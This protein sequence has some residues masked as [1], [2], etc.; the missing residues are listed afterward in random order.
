MRRFVISFA[1]VVL[2]TMG[3][4]HDFDA[5]RPEVERGT[6]GEEVFGIFCDRMSGQLLREDLSGA[7][8]HGVC[9][10]DGGAFADK[11]DESALPPIED[12]L[13][14]KDG[15]PVP[16]G[17]QQAARGRA[18]ARIAALV[19]R[20]PDLIEALDA[21]FPDADVPVLDLDNADPKATCQPA[22][23]AAAVRR[24]GS[25]LADMLGRMVDLYND[26]TMPA[27]TRSM[28]RVLDF[29]KKNTEAQASVAR[30]TGREGYRPP[31]IDIGVA[32]P[33]MGYPRFRDLSAETL[34]LI[35]FDSDPYAA[36]PPRNPD[37]SRQR[38]PGAAYPSF[39]KML[40]VSHEE[41]RTTKSS[42]TALLKTDR[43]AILNLDRLSRPRENLELATQ[44]FFV[45]DNAFGSGAP[46]YIVKRDG[47]GFA[48]LAGPLAAP[49]VDKDKDGL[50]DVDALGRFVTSD[51]K[52]AP[53]PFPVAGASGGSRDQFGRALIANQ[54]IYDYVDTSHNFGAQ[55]LADT[56]PLVDPQKDVL[57]NA[58]GGAYV[59]FGPR[60]KAQKIYDPDPGRVDL[61][62]SSHAADD[63]PPSDLGTK[64]V[65]IDYDA[66]DPARAPIVDFVYA[67]GQT[68]GA[69]GT[70]DLLQYSRMLMTDQ[71]AVLAALVGDMLA[72]KNIADKHEEAKLKEKSLFWDELLDVVA[73]ITKDR[74]LLEDLL[75]A[76]A[77]P[78]VVQAGDVFGKFMSFNDRISY[79]RDDIN[80]QT[81]NM[82][83][84]GHN[85]PKTP[86]N[87]AAPDVGMNRSLFQRLVDVV[88]DGDGVALC[89]KDGAIVHAKGVPLAGKLD[90]PLIGTYKECEVLK[91]DNLSK[92]YLGSIVGKSAFYFRPKILREGVL[93]IGA[94]TVD[95]LQQ[96]TGLQGFWDPPDS[97][98]FR[99]KPELLNRMVFFDQIGDQTNLQTNTFL[100][101]LI[102]PWAGAASCPERIINDPDPGSPDASPDGLVHGLRSCAEGDWLQQRHPDILFMMENFGAY[103]ALAP[104]VKPFADHDREDLLIALFKTI[105][106]HYQSDK[107]TPPEC[108]SSNPQVAN[109]CSHGNI[110][111]YEPLLSEALPAGIFTSLHNLTDVLRNTTIQKCTLIDPATK[112]CAQASPVNGITI[113]ADAAEAL[114]NPDE[115]RAIG[116][117]D[118]AGNT[119]AKRNDGTTNPQ[120]TP[121][122]LML[123]ALQSVDDAFAADAAKDPANK[124]RQVKWRA[125]R[126]ALVDQF[127]A[128]NG[129][130]DS[131]TFKNPVISKLS[132]TLID[133]LRSQIWS[134]CPDSFVPP[135][136]RCGWLRDDLAKKMGDTV[137]SPLFASGMDV[138]DII[139]KDDRAKKELQALLLYFTDPTS[140]NE[141]LSSMRAAAT[142]GMQVLQNDD[143]LVP[144][145]HIMA[146]ALANSVRDENGNVVQTGMA[147]AT[148]SLLS[149]MS[150]RARDADGAPVCNREID[151]NQVL[152]LVLKNAVTPMKGKNGELRKTPF[153]VVVDVIGDVNRSDPTKSG[154]LEPSDF[155]AVSTEV[156][157]FL[158]NKERGLEQFYRIIKNGTQ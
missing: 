11:V 20:R 109:Y 18:L 95:T 37:G 142:D 153:D 2:A 10:K 50:P 131:A 27:S 83:A 156:S 19:K 121:L 140:K 76:L 135:Y 39:A 155:A 158:V 13:A 15:N 114:I 96:S 111:S 72:F 119:T 123:Q 139:R 136:T 129:T 54:P 99:P 87:R 21:V 86:V 116:L 106:R 8:F 127:L 151:P 134:H 82:T 147:D 40:E 58:L 4:C 74:A 133:L 24:L 110:V 104:L 120:V 75:L 62:K 130:G 63:P 90:L 107:G 146:E 149:R 145:Y 98:T 144:F 77:D 122:Y 152:T 60:V 56:R 12:G 148:T 117:K 47:R 150:A 112:K 51:G 67:L 31:E 154:R 79:D 124:D 5:S 88:N 14:D 132:P 38:V 30:F 16:V 33:M 108:D 89:N 59:T 29:F 32:R 25:E 44:L 84:G 103:K 65:A 23:G 92:F 64:P 100:R 3:A 26:D 71:N 66:F 55:L 34:R 97:K 105:H 157:E 35:S 28:A 17:A 94:A 57:M 137:K 138:L 7:S 93:G 91:V 141:A 69:K 9:H 143:D 36:D 80:N 43:D 68:L 52:P 61:W 102:G 73:A 126:S 81:I 85:P 41:L 101:D 1:P 115:S 49:F 45:Q 118:R 22:T 42:K 48:A 128:V 6:I 125:A 113:M 78:N 70:D 46:R 53:T